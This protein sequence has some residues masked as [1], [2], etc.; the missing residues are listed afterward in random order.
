MK[1]HSLWLWVGMV[2]LSAGC[3]FITIYLH[4]ASSSEDTL[5]QGVVINKW[6]SWD[7]GM[8]TVIGSTVVPAANPK[9]WNITVF[10]YYEKNPDKKKTFTVQ[11]P[12][13]YYES[14]QIGQILE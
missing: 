14:V 4:D 7:T 12:E 8:P 11:V 1:D 13:K 6:V 9:V 10:A 2:M 3:V 5:R